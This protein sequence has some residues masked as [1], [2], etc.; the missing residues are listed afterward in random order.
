MPRDRYQHSKIMSTYLDVSLRE[1]KTV[2]L[3]M[4]SANCKIPYCDPRYGAVIE[5]EKMKISYRIGDNHMNLEI[6]HDN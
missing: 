1:G 5:D 3:K 6:K 4:L 2:A